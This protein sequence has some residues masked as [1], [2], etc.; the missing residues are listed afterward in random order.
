[1]QGSHVVRALTAQVPVKSTGE[2]PLASEDSQND[3]ETGQNQSKT[4]GIA[5]FLNFVRGQFQASGSV[6]E[7]SKH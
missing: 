2:V 4:S 7:M 5:A 1:M 6:L 3:S